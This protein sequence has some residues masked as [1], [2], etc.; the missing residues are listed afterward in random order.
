MLYKTS[1][2]L[3]EKLLTLPESGMGYQIIKTKS[4]TGSKQYIFFNGIVGSDFGYPG[5]FSNYELKAIDFDI[6]I[7]NLVIDKTRGAIDSSFE[8][9]NGS[10]IQKF[11]RLSAFENDF[12]VDTESGRLLPG[13]FTTDLEDFLTM[14]IPFNNFDPIAYYSLPN[15]LP[16]K[17]LFYF[18]SIAGDTF[19]RGT[20]QPAFGQNGGGREYYF[21]N[22]TS[23]KSLISVNPFGYS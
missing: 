9:T 2:R 20:V 18:K 5:S 10:E 8:T 14:T 11:V 17:W 19:Q 12:R 16:I 22:G 4:F 15:P 13:S 1:D 6:D 3:A 7:S 21:K 23:E